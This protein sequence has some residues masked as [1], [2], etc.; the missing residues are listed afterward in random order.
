MSVLQGSI[1]LLTDTA[2]NF[3]AD[4]PTLLDGQFGIE[5]DGLLTTPKYKIGNGTTAWTELPYA[6][7]SGGG[8]WGSITGTLSS[9]TDLQASIDLKE[10]ITSGI[11]ASGTD[12]YTATASP[13]PEAYAIGQKFVVIFTNANTGAS[14]INLNSL[15]AKSI[16]KNTSLALASGDIT[17]GQAYLLVYDG[18][19]FQ[20]SGGAS[21]DI[22]Y[23]ESQLSLIGVLKYLTN[24]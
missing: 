4:N 12:T 7:S 24:T 22:S 23:N 3:T 11:T 1:Q 21:S 20:I 5:T 2:A 13:V 16:K 10:N 19:N 9:Q 17:A 14:T 15:G 6:S 8:T 18:T